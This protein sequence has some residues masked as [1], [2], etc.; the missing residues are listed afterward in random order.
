[1]KVEYV[2]DE[3]GGRALFSKGMHYLVRVN[4]SL[5][6]QGTVWFI[7]FSGLIIGYVCSIKKWFKGVKWTSF[8]NDEWSN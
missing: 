5:G 3:K 2:K 8:I 7:R 4:E 1:M 6:S